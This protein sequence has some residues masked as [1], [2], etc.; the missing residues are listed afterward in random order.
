[1]YYN[2]APRITGIDSHINLDNV[3]VSSRG[4]RGTLFTVH[5]IP[6]MKYFLRS[7]GELTT[8]GENV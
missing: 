5:N 2:T 1:M 4:G 8:S 7:A 3:S 6:E